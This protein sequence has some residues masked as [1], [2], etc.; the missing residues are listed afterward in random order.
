MKKFL[1]LMLVVMMVLSLAACGSKT[2][3]PAKTETEPSTEV[4]T[5]APADAPEEV[6]PNSGE[7]IVDVSGLEPEAA[8][9]PATLNIGS[10]QDEAHTGDAWYADG[11]KGGSY[12]YFEA[13]DNA[14]SGLAYVKMANGEKV[15]TI[16]CK[17]TEDKH[18]VDQEA[19]EGKSGIDIVFSDEFKAYDH[20]SGTWYVRGNPEVLG[21]LFEGVQLVCQG[22]ESNTLILNAGGTGTE[23]FEGQ[24]FEISWAMNS[25]STVVFN[26]GDYNYTLEIVTDESG[27]LVSLNEQNL[28]IFVPAA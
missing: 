17:L 24:E 1:T 2:E 15:E 21:Q 28:R 14:S 19:E 5:E 3:E 7:Q 4:S 23:V 16:L 13:A 10:V 11:V 25:A 12:I 6:Q 26:D 9:N 20:V 8:V 18:L 27:K 22:N